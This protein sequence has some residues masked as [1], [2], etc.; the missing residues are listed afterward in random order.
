MLF[1][2]MEVS[3]TKTWDGLPIDHE[4]VTIRLERHSGDQSLQMI[5]KS[6]FFNDPANPGGAV[7]QPFLGLWDYEVVELFLAND[8]DQYVEIELCP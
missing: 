5:V 1:S 2:A 4:P 3:I 8:K 7:G 6:P